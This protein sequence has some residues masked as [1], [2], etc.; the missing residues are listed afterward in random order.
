[1]NRD[2]STHKAETKTLSDT[3]CSPA[4]FKV[5]AGNPGAIPLP[6]SPPGALIAKTA[7]KA[8]PVLVGNKGELKVDAGDH[9]FLGRRRLFANQLQF[10]FIRPRGRKDFTRPQVVQQRVAANR[11]R[12]PCGHQ[13]LTAPL[14]HP[15]PIAAPSAPGPGSPAWAPGS[16]A[17]GGT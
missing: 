2:F 17:P 4:G 11:A 1:M 3:N 13:R 15:G 5:I 7:E 16:A 14:R 10:L 12:L 8:D 6:A 9:L